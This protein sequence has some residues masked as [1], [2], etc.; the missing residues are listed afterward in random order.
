[1][2][3]QVTTVTAG[4]IQDICA[5]PVAADGIALGGLITAVMNKIQKI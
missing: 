4:A 2:H 5:V 3:Q 1:M